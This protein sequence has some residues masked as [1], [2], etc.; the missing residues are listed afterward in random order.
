VAAASAARR[1]RTR[2]TSRTFSWQQPAVLVLAALAAVVPVASGLWWLGRG[3]AGPLQRSDP[4]PLPAFVQA[5]AA[6]PERSRTLVLLPEEGRLGYTLLRDRPAQFGDVELAAPVD[7][8]RALDGLVAD[9]ASGRGGVAVAELSGYAVQFILVSAPVDPGLEATLDS[10]PGLLRVANPGDA[11]L[12]RLDRPTGR[13]QLAAADPDELPLLLPSG[14]VDATADVPAGSAD[15]LLVVSESRDRWWRATLGG[16]S[17]PAQTVDDWAQG[18][19]VSAEAGTLE[20]TH[21]SPARLG[22]LVGEGVLV[23]AV[24]VAALPSRR[25]DDEVV[26]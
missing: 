21:R 4:D 16:R 24:V 22:W 7:T 5:E 8:R 9:I 6:L 11:A 25:R 12:W 10:V 23:L 20:L 3:A 19:V 1:S 17:L 2:L 14:V 13:L 15:R 26:L 18:F